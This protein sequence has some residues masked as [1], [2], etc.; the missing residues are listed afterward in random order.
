MLEYHKTILHKVS[1]SQ[2]IFERELQKGLKSLAQKDERKELLTWAKQM[3][4]RGHQDAFDKIMQQQKQVE[5][6]Y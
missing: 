4:G 2:S 5:I 3:F 1:F 6:T